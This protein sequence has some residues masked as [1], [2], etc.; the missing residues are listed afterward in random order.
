MELTDMM[1]LMFSSFQAAL[2]K[3]VLPTGKFQQNL[4]GW[5]VASACAHLQSICA[6]PVSLNQSRCPA[7]ASPAVF[8]HCFRCQAFSENNTK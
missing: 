6:L 5:H 4:I 1:I 7:T 3:T 8:H 2:V